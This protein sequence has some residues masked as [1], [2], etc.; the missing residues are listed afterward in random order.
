[1]TAH[2]LPVVA[3]APDSREPA[4]RLDPRT[5]ARGL[6]CVHC[7]LCLPACPTYT[8]NG[9]EADSPRGRIQLMLGLHEGKIEATEAVRTHLDRCLDCRACETA[10]PSNVVYHELIEETRAKLPP[11]KQSVGDRLVRWAFLNVLTKPGRLKLAL[12]GPRVLQKLGV[13]PL[14]RKAGVFNLLPRGLRK[15]EGMLPEKGPVW[16]TPIAYY[17]PPV[18]ER[19]EDGWRPSSRPV[20]NL[21]DFPWQ[22]VAVAKGT[23][24]VRLNAKGVTVSFFT[25]CVGSVMFDEVNRKAVQLL[26][27]AGCSVFV[28]PFQGC[29]GAI[30]H[31]NGLH[32]EAEHMA[33]R[34]IHDLTHF[35][36]EEHSS[37][38]LESDKFFVVS[39]VA[40][41]GAMLRDYATLLRDDPESAERAKR[42]AARVRDVTEVLAELGLPEMPHR[43]EMTVTYH[44]ACHLVHAQK[45]AAQPR[46]LLA[47]V[48]GL[49]LVPLPESDMC[50]GA[51]GTY[52]LTHPEMAGD[53]AERKLKHVDATG[54]AV[55]V[56][57]NVGCSMHLAAADRQR[58]GKLTIVHPVEI[59]HRAVF[60]GDPRG[61]GVPEGH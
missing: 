47:K 18:S 11:A 8:Q 59:L 12:L 43:V 2:P 21:C 13:Y 37:D 49:T 36:G 20:G 58:G 17:S 48:P 29:C 32:A 57:G 30:H 19:T 1:M 9:L 38:L 33:R 25:G 7:G 45:V 6:S 14:L 23:P 51:A 61:R 24:G 35:A 26:N 5:Y 40:G 16:P 3:P 50:C 52:N 56:T 4:V 53:L 34:V 44:D 15:M 42:F 60:G 46:A 55:C 31:H 54:A 41:C 10:C 27:A 28:V 39:T 22:I